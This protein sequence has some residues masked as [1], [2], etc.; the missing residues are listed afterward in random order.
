MVGVVENAAPALAQA[1]PGWYA[2]RG[3][4]WLSETQTDRNT[5]QDL[6]GNTFWEFK[7]QINHN[8]LRRTVKYNRKVHHSD[9]QVS[10]QWHQWLRKTRWEPPTMQEQAADVA[11]QTQLK[12][13][14][15]LADER[16]AA[17]AKYIEQPK[18][19]ARSLPPK[20]AGR[21][22][23]ATGGSGS[24]KWQPESWVPGGTK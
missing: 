24:S 17:K 7:D 11:R 5:G 22:A 19:Q 13:N 10:P 15:R 14:A 6:M 2:F 23:G 20:E 8:R 16:W 3:P 12:H 4:D 21:T 1:I 18:P 9:V